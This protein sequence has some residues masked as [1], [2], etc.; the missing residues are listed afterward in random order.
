LKL[1]YATI[2]L[3]YLIHHPLP[4]LSLPLFSALISPHSIPSSPPP[5]LSL[6]LSLL[7][8]HGIKAVFEPIKIYRWRGDK[9][10]IFDLLRINQITSL[11]INKPS[12]S[13]FPF[14]LR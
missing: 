5:R 7:L 13:L 14:L 6:S 11:S 1:K 2:N 4:Y 8:I 9:V 3:H 10:P 12:F